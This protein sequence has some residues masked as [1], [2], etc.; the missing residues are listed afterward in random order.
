MRKL[1]V[2]CLLLPLAGYSQQRLHLTL[3]GGFSNYQG[4]LQSKY[5]TLNQSNL[6]V[7]AGSAIRFHSEYRGQA[8]F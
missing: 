7:G 4:D 8:R 3:M 2:W 1:L 5:F 6:A